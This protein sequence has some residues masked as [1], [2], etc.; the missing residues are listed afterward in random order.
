ML[1]FKLLFII[2]TWGM[3]IYTIFQFYLFK[4]GKTNIFANKSDILVVFWIVLFL[5]KELLFI[6]DNR[7]M[8]IMIM[9]LLLDICVF[10]LAAVII[11]IKLPVNTDFILNKHNAT[12][13]L[14]VIVPVLFVVLMLTGASFVSAR[15]NQSNETKTHKSHKVVEH[16]TSYKLN[17]TSVSETASH[18]YLKVSGSTKA[19]NGSKIFT[20][21]GED[22][23]TTTSSFNDTNE[24][25][26][27]SV[28]NGKFTTY[29][30]ISDVS[31]DEDYKVGTKLSFI[32]FAIDKMNH[33]VT[34]DLSSKEL[35]KLSKNGTTLNY[36]ISKSIH[37]A[38]YVKDDD[39]DSSSNVSDIDESTYTD[40]MKNDISDKISDDDS[41]LE[42]KDVSVSGQFEIN[43][44]SMAITI[45]SDNFSGIPS[46][47]YPYILDAISICQKYNPEKFD[48]IKFILSG[49]LTGGAYVP[50]QSYD[51]PGKNLKNLKAD[52]LDVDGLEAISSEHFYRPNNN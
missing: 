8:L 1:F 7:P 33:S 51:I 12:K 35:S 30:S 21:T 48:N 5:I 38:L 14:G 49:K 27:S 41:L 31:S 2:L 16:F 34:Y 15:S 25:D 22:D 9:L 24:S 23:S 28:K 52:T 42:I 19:P 13:V 11:S 29:V 10:I 50:I 44:M 39:D 6:T 47:D 20:T 3:G 40:D 18:K 4:E 36:T 32:S 37:D 26:W 43:P 45:K 46:K 17:V